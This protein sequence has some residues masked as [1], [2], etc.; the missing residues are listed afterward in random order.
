MYTVDYFSYDPS[1][2]SRVHV[3]IPLLGDFTKTVTS[4]SS[5]LGIFTTEQSEPY[6]L[7]IG[8]KKNTAYWKFPSLRE[9]VH[10]LYKYVYGAFASIET[11]SVPYRLLQR[12]NNLLSSVYMHGFYHH[13]HTTTTGHVIN[14][15]IVFEDSIQA[16]V[17]DTSGN[18][19]VGTVSK[20]NAVYASFPSYR[21]LTRGEN[22][23]YMSEDEQVAC[24]HAIAA[25]ANERDHKAVF[26][27]VD[28]NPDNI[29]VIH[30]SGQQPGGARTEIVLMLC[31][32]GFSNDAIFK[33]RA[34][35]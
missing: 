18:L 8:M 25:L 32:L 24:N 15:Y 34:V 30:R 35:N 22:V 28:T 14:V 21:K 23:A 26:D 17:Y 12:Y 10:D 1:P 5:S 33:G 16:T 4:Q 11:D 2:T 7:K 29:F 31:D 19:L 6:Y 9:R 27:A 3:N 13:E 20:Y